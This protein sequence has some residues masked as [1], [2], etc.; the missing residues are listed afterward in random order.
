[1][2]K[3][4]KQIID[5]ILEAAKIEEVVKDCIGEYGPHNKAGLKKCGVRYEALCP[6]HDDKSLGSFVVYPRGNCYKCF[7]CGAKGGVIDFLM[8]REGLSYPD[9]IDGWVRSTR[10]TWTA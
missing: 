8:T 7:S 10:S 3:I 9:A 5:K 6:F 1:M 2:A 4:D